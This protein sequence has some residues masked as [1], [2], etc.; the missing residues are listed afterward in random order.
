GG[1][2]PPQ[3][4]ERRLRLYF[5]H[6]P[7]LPQ[8]P[9]CAVAKTWAKLAGAGVCAATVLTV[10]LWRNEPTSAA[11]KPDLKPTAHWVFDGNGVTGKTVADRAG[12][13]P[14]AL[15]GTPKVVADGP[16]PHLHL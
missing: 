10:A 5:R 16:A 2:H 14:G 4:R 8:P 3:R 12:K 1:S 13:M 15:L 6:L 11:P 7:T 9:G